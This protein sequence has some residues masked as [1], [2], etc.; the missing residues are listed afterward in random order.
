MEEL[1]NTRRILVRKQLRKKPLGKPRMRWPLRKY[2]G[3]VR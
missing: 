1:R 3:D 2:Y